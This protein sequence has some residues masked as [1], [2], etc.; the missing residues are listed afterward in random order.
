ME[1]TFAFYFPGA[2]LTSTGIWRLTDEIEIAHAIY[3]SSC[4]G[5]KEPG[6]F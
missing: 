2:E 5:A 6:C 3:S 4:A 1:F